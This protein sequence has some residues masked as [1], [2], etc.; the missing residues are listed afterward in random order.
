M[1]R[2]TDAVSLSDLSMDEL[3][4]RQ[5]AIMADPKNRNPKHATGSIFLYTAS[6]RKKLDAI[7]WAI[8]YKLSESKKGANREA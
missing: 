8:T 5:Q 7:A 1:P 3:H 2:A 6:A 4:A